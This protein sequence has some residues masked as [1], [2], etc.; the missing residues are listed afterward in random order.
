[1]EHKEQPKEKPSSRNWIIRFYGLLIVLLF[2]S[3][4]PYAG[5]WNDG[6]RLASVEAIVD[7]HTLRIDNSIFVKIPDSLKIPEK[8]PYPIEDYMILKSGTLDKLKIGD[9]YYTDKP[10]VISLMMAIPYKI[11]RVCGGPAFSE[12][13][14][15]ACWFLTLIIM[16]SSLIYLTHSLLAIA[17]K[18]RFAEDQQLILVSVVILSTVVITYTQ[19]LNNHLLLLAVFAGMINQL[20]ELK[21]VAPTS[22]QHKLRLIWLGALAS[23]AYNLD[24]GLAAPLISLLG[25]ITWYTHRRIL[26]CFWMLVGISPGLAA[27]LLTNLILG[28]GLKPLNS[29]P[30]Y[31]SWPGSPFSTSNMTGLFQHHF[32]WFCLYSLELLF[33]KNGFVGHN[34]M[35]MFSIAIL[36]TIP[37][38][39]YRP[40]AITLFALAWSISGWLMYGALS[41][42]GG[43]GCCGVRWFLPFLVT[44]FLI[45]LE[46]L[47]NHPQDRRYLL[48]LAFW[49]GI[50]AILMWN[51][52]TWRRKML[53]LFWP[54]QGI[55][56]T[57]WF[58]DYYL[59]NMRKKSSL[60]SID[61]TAKQTEQTRQAA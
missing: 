46:W 35:L 33:G 51:Y 25:M 47:K 1:M 41:N 49:G 19:H 26:D 4:R 40:S 50:E 9:H 31:L 37:W 29:V 59:H 61:P 27:Y 48:I 5:G 45:N 24:L 3:V 12:N 10:I 52:G 60:S 6:S 16:G 42:N 34:L 21:S 58:V 17:K 23:I 57:H 20:M 39:K 7:H 36:F 55:A 56:V 15:Y 18:Y 32:G 54:I 30:E 14:R 8:L 38:S 44:G 2:I 13:P 11:W 22:R 28:G 53:P 43:G